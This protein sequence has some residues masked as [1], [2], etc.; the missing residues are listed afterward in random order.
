[1]S[2]W[3]I[4]NKQKLFQSEKRFSRNKTETRTTDCEE[5]TYEKLVNLVWHLNELFDF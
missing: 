4:Q 3:G 2:R 5:S 1:M